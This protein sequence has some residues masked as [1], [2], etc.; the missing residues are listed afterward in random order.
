M[1]TMYY[2]YVKILA[3]KERDENNLTN[4]E[5]Y[6]IFENI[7]NISARIYYLDCLNNILSNKQSG[8]MYSIF[9]TDV[10]NYNNFILGIDKEI[11]FHESKQIQLVFDEKKVL[12]EKN[13]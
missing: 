6:V 5:K 2:F 12:S 3:R 11:K 4:D 1:F 7:L 9:V 8:N 13:K 10:I